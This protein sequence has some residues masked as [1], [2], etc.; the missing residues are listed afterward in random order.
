MYVAALRRLLEMYPVGAS[1]EQLLYH[2]RTSGARATAADILQSLNMLSGSGEATIVAN[3]RWKLAKFSSADFSTGGKQSRSGPGSP[4]DAPGALLAVVGHL[5]STPPAELDFADENASKDSLPDGSAWRLDKYWRALLS[6]YAATQRADPRGKVTQFT[7]LHGESWQLF[8]ICGC[9]WK[10][11]DLRFAMEALPEKFREALTHRKENICA[12]GYPITVFDTTGVVEFVPALLVTASWRIANDELG[13]IVGDSDPVINPDWL[14]RICTATSWTA[15]DLTETLLPLGEDCDLGAV[16]SRLRHALAKIGGAGLSPANPAD[17]LKLGLDGLRNCAAAFLPVDARFTQGTAAD[18]DAMAA[19]PE[20]D[21]RRSAV[22][23]LFSG[24]ERCPGLDDK[25]ISIPLLQIREMTDRQ[26]DAAQAALTGTLTVI[27]GPPGTGK[28]DVV[29]SLLLSIFMARQTVLFA[30]K[31]HQAL[32]EVETRLSKLVGTNPALTRGR[33]AEGDRDTNFLAAMKELSASEPRFGTSPP[34]IDDLVAAADV[35]TSNRVL[36]KT[37]A[38]LEI[39]LANL[40]ERSLVL[41][42]AGQPTSVTKLSFWRKVLNFASKFIRHPAVSPDGPVREDALI[43]GIRRRIEFLKAKILALPK[44]EPATLYADAT[45]RTAAQLPII[46]RFAEFITQIDAFGRQSLLDRVKEMEFSGVTKSRKLLPDDARLLLKHRPIWA[47]STLPVPSRVPL[48]AGLFDYLV[49]DEA[50]QC[51]IASA[52]PLLA[53]ARRVVVVGDPLQLSFIPQLSRQQEHALMDAAGIPKARRHLIAQSV[54]SIFEFAEKRPTSRRMFLA[55]QF[56]SASGIVDYING[57]FYGGRLVARREDDE[58]KLP[59][60]YKPGLE[61]RDVKGRPGWEDGGNINAIEADAIVALIADLVRNRMFSGSIG[62]LSPFTAQVGRLIRLTKQALTEEERARIAL[63]VATIDKFQG[64]EADVI[65]FSPV[66]AAGAGF[67]IVNFLKR[68]RRRLNV[69]ISRARALCLVVGDLSYALNSDIPHI[70]NLARRA[71]SPF[72]P[73]REGFDSEWERRL[74]VAMR[75]RGLKPHSQYPVGRKYLD[76]ALFGP[77]VKL[78]VEVDGRAFHVD[79][80]GNRKTS[81]L[82]RD[83]ELMARGWKVRRFWVS[84]MY[85]DMESCLDRIESDLR[86]N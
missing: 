14:K 67:G 38:E 20:E 6:Y 49:V 23:A 50:S 82:L 60:D 54:N 41:E 33:D 62:V 85:Y 3:G 71:T 79:P 18:L 13:I 81:D 12:L 55:D 44:P 42:P 36:H 45:E 61:W 78:D 7:D 75:H 76:F 2:L 11:A 51:D 86:P 22:F 70:R 73:P 29:V 4:T 74:D 68:E 8:A 58:L 34:A 39:E 65:L 19:W 84:E 32:D 5:L 25:R 1:S 16:A 10:N 37:R 31:N 80:D 53:R 30:S 83:K 40:I 72:S 66:I 52:L 48:V 69:A 43:G 24:N 64:G 28:S 27:Q 59:R 21:L 15:D 26:F 47:I 9:W 63:K 35:E 77:G 57:E 46:E 56:R 17:E